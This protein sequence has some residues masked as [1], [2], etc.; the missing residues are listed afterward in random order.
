[1]REGEAA[2]VRGDM[3]QAI[4]A[5]RRALEMDPQL[6]DAALYAGDAEFKKGYNSTNPQFRLEHFAAAGTWFAK[7]VAINPNRET[8][9]RYWGDAL[10]ATGKTN[11]A[12][13]R[14]VEAIIADPY[15]RNAYV[16]LTQWAERHKV[17]LGH[18]KIEPPATP[19]NQN[20]Q[21]TINIDPR[22]MNS[23]DGSNNW[24]L[25][26]LTRTAW[27]KADFFKNYP[28][29][30]Q[31]RHSLKEEAAALRMVAEACAKDLRSGKVK[32]L[33]ASL[34]M[35]VKL[36]EDGFL[37][38]YVLFARPDEGIARDYFPYRALNR[39]KLKQY[40]LNVVIIA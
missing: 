4:A 16:G 33:E 6:Y 39:D 7:A 2:F 9:Y 20:G 5:Y 11:D 30:K 10:D 32:A 21:T 3:D 29:E 22:T 35:L 26:S 18:P 8:A 28:A 27:A 14:F 1:M 12:R 38:A 40:W 13:D 36:N 31:Y 23:T 17:N 15:S 19:A 37:E 34:A 25:Y 24:L